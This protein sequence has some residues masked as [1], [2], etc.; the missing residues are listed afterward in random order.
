[1]LIVQLS[2]GKVLNREPLS[3]EELEG[4]SVHPFHAKPNVPF[5]KFIVY[6][7]C[8]LNIPP[9]SIGKDVAVV[10]VSWLLDCLS[11]FEICDLRNICV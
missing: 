1:M 9:K 7:P 4:G 5:Y 6:D 3:S 2:G 10:P 11:N 8:T